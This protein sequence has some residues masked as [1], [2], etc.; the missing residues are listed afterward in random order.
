MMEAQPEEAT[1][2]VAMSPLPTAVPLEVASACREQ[3]RFPAV[4]VR[5]VRFDG[6]LEHSARVRARERAR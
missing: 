2:E 4:Q 3:E 6:P 1:L 5:Q